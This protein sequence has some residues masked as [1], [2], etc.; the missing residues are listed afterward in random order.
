MSH[1]VIDT[2]GVRPGGQGFG[3]RS[4][5]L[6]VFVALLQPW[7]ASVAN[8]AGADGFQADT[9][10]WRARRIER[11]TAADG[12]LT[13]VGLDWLEPGE[14]NFGS[15]PGNRIVLRGASVPAIAGT[16]ILDRGRLRVSVRKGAAVTIDAKPVAE[17]ELHDDSGGEPSILRIG[18]LSI[19]VVKRGERWAARV[20]DSASP[21]RTGFRGL[22][23]FA[24]DARFRVDATLQP[25]PPGKT[26]PILNVL[27]MTDLESSPGALQFELQ[28]QRY[29]VEPVQE[30]GSDDLFL[31]IADATSGKETYGAGRFVAV[32][33]GAAPGHWIIDFNRAYNPPCAFTPYATCPL[34]PKG[35]RLPLRITAG[36]KRYA[37]GHAE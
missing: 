13:L 30:D 7:P 8:A 5:A 12:W 16:L 24:A 15:H 10:A 9:D 22:E 21:V 36:E 14:N 29:R 32:T 34:P 19:Q 28:G 18:T 1:L 3:W 26:L 37:G 4:V 35:N 6:G 25:Y 31:M 27:G 20:K 2:H 11:L 17:Q 33:R 23:W